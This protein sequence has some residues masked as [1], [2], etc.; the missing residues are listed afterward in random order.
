VIADQRAT[1]A[2]RLDTALTTI[3]PSTPS[4]ATRVCSLTAHG[5]PYGG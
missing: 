3:D 1:I 5:V 2:A 4:P